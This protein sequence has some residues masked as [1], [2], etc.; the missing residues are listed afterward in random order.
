ML[1]L[2]YSRRY[3]IRSASST[4]T[5]DFND[6]N[7][8]DNDAVD[9]NGDNNDNNINVSNIIDTIDRA[10]IYNCITI[11]DALLKISY[12]L[13]IS[14]TVVLS[15]KAYNG[16]RDKNLKIDDISMVLISQGLDINEGIE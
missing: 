12:L 2:I 13:I 9:D 6:G 11:L 16:R 7:D 5:N 15:P 10:K 8:C 4:N 1:M 3:L 14:I